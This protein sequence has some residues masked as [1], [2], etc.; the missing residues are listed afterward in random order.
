MEGGVMIVGIGIGGMGLREIE[1]MMIVMMDMEVTD[2]PE[3]GHAS[4]VD[5][6]VIGNETVP[7]DT[8]KVSPHST[9]ITPIR[10]H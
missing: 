4:F 7:K 10:Y 2:A 9:I 5:H 1:D 6:T 3:V 8:V